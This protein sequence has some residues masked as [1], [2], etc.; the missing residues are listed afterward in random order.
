MNA[1]Q[2]SVPRLLIIGAGFGGLKAAAEAAKHNLAITVVDRRNHHTFQPL[3][4]QVAT[5]GLSPGEIA[6]PI[7]GVLRKYS[8]IEVLLGEV[9][10]FDLAR[11][12]VGLR[13]GSELSYDY[14]IVASGATHS[15]FGHNEWEELAP[16]LKTIE[17]ATEIRRRVLLAFELA[18]RHA[19]ISGR[20]EPVHFVVVGGGPTGVE[21]AG[22]MAEVAR[23]ALARNFRHIDPTATRI[24]LLEGGP[25]VL[26]AYPPDLSRSAQQQLERLGVQVRTNAQVT[27]VEPGQVRV[28][29]EVLPATVTLWAAGVRASSLG[30]K[31]GVEIDRAGRVLVSPDLSVPGHPEVFVVG[32]LANLKDRKSGDLLPG[33]APV[34]MQEGHHAAWNI[35]RDLKSKPRKPFHYVD[36]GTMATIGRAAAIAKIG[37]L[38]VSGFIAWMMWLFVHIMFLVG[39]RNRVLVMLEWAWSYLTY[40]RSA[41]LITGSTYLPGWNAQQHEHES[42]EL[43]VEQE[44]ERAKYA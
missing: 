35:G 1:S 41:R 14:L 5:A 38:H 34:A 2:N 43:S 28:G 7:R 13:D 42:D 39:F 15:Y 27:A 16:G 44:H 9:D 37:K 6:A 25:R 11:K 32:D 8:N 33:V 22:T 17:D 12:K 36:K 30:K 19:H 3:L 20:S 4:Y 24:L 10:S 18:E 31:L 21:L 40:Q 23:K 26:P 29:E